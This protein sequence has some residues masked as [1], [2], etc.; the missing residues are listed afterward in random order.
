LEQPATANVLDPE[1]L[2]LLLYFLFFVA[3][4]MTLLH[5]GVIRGWDMILDSS[6]LDA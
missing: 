6:Y 2:G 5:L 4:L 3:L 1:A